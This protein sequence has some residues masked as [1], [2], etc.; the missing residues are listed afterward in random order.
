[1]SDLNYL[2]TSFIAAYLLPEPD[3]EQVETI[4]RSLSAGSLQVSHWTGTEMASLLARKV[5]MQ[6][7]SSHDSLKVKGGYDRLIN[8]RV[9]RSVDIIAEDFLKA[10]QWVIDAKLGLRGPNGL[11]LAVA[12][13]LDATIWTLDIKMKEIANRLGLNTG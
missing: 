10:S 8:D 9:F 5:R 1:L 13:R 11:H 4:L 7:L 2:D 6:D 12:H 3:S